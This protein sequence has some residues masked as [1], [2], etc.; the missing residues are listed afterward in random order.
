MLLSVEEEIANELKGGSYQRDDEGYSLVEFIIHCF[1]KKCAEYDYD[2]P[3]RTQMDSIVNRLR[4]ND[5]PRSVVA[6]YSRNLI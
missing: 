2:F 4:Y 5:N 3:T 1:L 6:F